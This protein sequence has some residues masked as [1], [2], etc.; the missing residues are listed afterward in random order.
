MEDIMGRAYAKRFTLAEIKAITAF[1]KSE[2]GK[3]MLSTGPQ[4]M[5]EAMPEI[6][7]LTS[8][9]INA[10]MQEFTKKAMDDAKAAADA[11]K[12]PPAK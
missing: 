6:M 5:Q 1:Y 2:A 4:L 9:K 10:L 11:K 7:A 12:T 8:P 3:K